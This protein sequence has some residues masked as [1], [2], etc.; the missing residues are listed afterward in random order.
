MRVSWLWTK[1]NLSIRELSRIYTFEK[2]TIDIIASRVTN[3]KAQWARR[4]PSYDI[5]PDSSCHRSD[6]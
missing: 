3:F 6:S 4:R 1:R 2:M 5:P